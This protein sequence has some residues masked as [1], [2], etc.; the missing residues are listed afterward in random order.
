MIRSGSGAYINIT[1]E[2]N[3]NLGSNSNNI[4]VGGV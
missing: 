3:I 1:S 4:V 2:S